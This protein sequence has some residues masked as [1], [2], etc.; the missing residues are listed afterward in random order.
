MPVSTCFRTPAA[1]AVLLAASAIFV[2]ACG[3]SG[4]S[5]PG[6]AG[7]ATT[8]AGSGGGA[9]LANSTP[10]TSPSSGEPGIVAVTTAGALV[11]LDPS[12]GS[13]TQTLVPSGVLGDEVSVSPD[14]AT[15]Y[16]AVSQGCKAAIESV[17]I[18]G[19][20]PTVIGQGELPAISP[21]GSKLAFAI[22]PSLTQ[23]CVPNTSNLAGLYKLVIRAVSSG[24]EQVLPLPPQVRRGGLPSPISHLSWAADSTRLAVS[25][26]AVADNEGW[27][28]WIVDTS[29]AKYYVQPGSGVTF[30]PVTGSPTPQRSYL[31]EGIFLPDG[32]LF[33]SRACCG[34]VPIHNTSRLMWVV[35]L[36]GN[37]VHQVAIGFAN[38]DHYSLATDASGQWLLYLAG[39]DLYVSRGGNRPS[40]LGSGFIAATWQ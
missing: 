29:V 24:A 40:L 25:A 12:T 15:V 7:G 5:T 20:S 8:P 19:G 30:V 23:G 4:S 17:P 39:H 18:G 14:G 28:I 38:L 10:A 3:S 34:G 33:I 35:D 31:R 16:F 2:A 22:E 6:S 21:D 9:G 27:N 1:A 26:S 32:N 11:R 13:A 37:L 36:S